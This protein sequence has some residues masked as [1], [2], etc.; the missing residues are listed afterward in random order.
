MRI[1]F[2][3]ITFII[4]YACE[5]F[6][7]YAGN[8]EIIFK[9]KS[10]AIVI[11]KNLFSTMRKSQTSISACALILISFYFSLF[12]LDSIYLP[13]LSCMLY[14]AL[15]QYFMIYMLHCESRP[16]LLYL[17]FD[18]TEKVLLVFWLPLPPPSSLLLLLLMRWSQIKSLNYFEY[19]VSTIFF[20]LILSFALAVLS[21][22]SSSWCSS[23]FPQPFRRDEILWE[24]YWN[25]F[26]LLSNFVWYK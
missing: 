21:I 17:V 13:L 26:I 1:R 12:Y 24:K 4:S 6:V 23:S 10:S 5:C 7:H 8:P 3:S 15:L 22:S 25:S 2:C 16:N 19:F 18:L 14:Q 11:C 20:F 9:I